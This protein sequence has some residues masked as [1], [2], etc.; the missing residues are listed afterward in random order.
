MLAMIR[1]L[2]IA[3]SLALALPAAAQ[4]AP[5]ADYTDM[6]WNPNESGW[7]ISFMQSGASGQAYATWYTYDARTTDPA[8]QQ[9]KPL[10]IVM[11]GGTWTAP[12]TITGR[13]YVLN[14]VPYNQSGTNRTT[15]DVGTFT[16]SFSSVSS[17]T[18]TYEI[19]PPPGLPASDPAYNLPPM[20]GSRAITRFSF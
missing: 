6:W 19:A 1:R 3:A 9:H 4:S 7:G 17:G 15:T 12:N 20:S 2:L 10:W 13:A 11:T 8:T 18:F 16:L 5:N 14:G